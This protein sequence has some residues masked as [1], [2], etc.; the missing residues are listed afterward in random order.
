MLVCLARNKRPQV[1]FIA[2]AAVPRVTYRHA[3]ADLIDSHLKKCEDYDALC[4]ACRTFGWV[5]EP[6]MTSVISFRMTRR[7]PVEAG[8]WCRME[9]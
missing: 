9:S 7:Q 6:M 5:Y 8:F 3:I 1:E 4:P 2:P